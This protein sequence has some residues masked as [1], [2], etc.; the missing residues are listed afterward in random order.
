ME[1]IE[2]WSHTLFYLLIMFIGYFFKK[3][4]LLKKEDSQILAT[5][6]MNL[7]LPC[8]FFSSAKGIVL[9]ISMLEL[10]IIGLVSNLLMIVLGYVFMRKDSD[11]M[12]GTY[13]IA[14]SGYDVGNF[15]LPFV[16]AFFSGIGVIYLCSFNITN[17][18]M[19]LGVTYAI[20]YYVVNKK[21]DLKIKD[22]LKQ[23]FSSI[24]LDVYVLII[25]LAILHID[26]PDVL[27]NVTSKIGSVNTFLVMM[28]I[29]LKLEFHFNFSH[30]QHIISI[31]GMRFVGAI[32]LTIIT[33]LLPLPI[34][35][36]KVII[37]AY[38]GLLVSVSSIYA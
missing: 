9:D 16:T 10:M 19:S 3:I 6:I 17:T 18:I 26:I 21:N 28:M 2:I 34:L 33:Y 29:G 30:V 4:H 11:L 5:I 7:T 20:A 12:K 8:V 14:C 38:F 15:V 32:I 25:I 23:L 35:A 36:K 24:S 27:I 31:L 37:L 1:M 22:F 13:M